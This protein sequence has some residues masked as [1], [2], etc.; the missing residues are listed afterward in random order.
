VT[1]FG[2]REDGSN[3]FRFASLRVFGQ[4]LVAVCREHYTVL[5]YKSRRDGQGISF[6]EAFLAVA[7]VWLAQSE[8]SS[9][10]QLSSVDPY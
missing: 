7:S 5:A 8:L 1:T 4:S 6:L 2:C 10:T 3:D 9:A